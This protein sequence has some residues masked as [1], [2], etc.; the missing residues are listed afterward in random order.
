MK[1]SL[2]SKPTR[3]FDYFRQLGGIPLWCNQFRQRRMAFAYPF[4]SE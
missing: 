4:Q 1:R 2:Y 3:G